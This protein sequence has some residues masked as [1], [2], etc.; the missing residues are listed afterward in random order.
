MQRAH[1][2]GMAV[3]N[4]AC[5]P[6]LTGEW[7]FPAGGV[8]LSASGSFPI[9][10]I[11]LER[12]ELLAGRTPRTI[13]MS[14]IGNDLQHASPAI[15][16]LIVYNSNPVAVAPQS[17][18]VARGFAREDLFTV[19]LEHF[20]TD[21]ADYADYILPA[22][23]QLEH[24]D[25]HCTYGHVSVVLNQPAIAPLGEAK[26]NAEIFR[27]L[28]RHMGYTDACFA[29]TDEAIGRQAFALD[30]PRGKGIDWNVLQTQG[31]Q[32]LPWT[33][34]AG[35]F[36]PFANGGFGTP[37]GK[38]EFFSA[39]MQAAGLDPVPAY[40]APYE[41][42]E[43]GSSSK[44]PLAFI[45]PPARNFL[46]STF[47]NVQSLRNTEGEPS[48]EL[49]PQDAAARGIADGD[50]VRVFND[51]GSL[52]LRAR[53]TDKARPR[54]VV[55]LSIWWKKLAADGKNAN[56]LVNQRL[57]DIGEAP[58]FYDCAVEVEAVAITGTA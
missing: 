8:L 49:H 56:E 33:G 51:R 24:F 23:T 32:R 45:S 35:A 50:Q 39:S 57:T 34:E 12:P 4:I 17:A 31:W 53:V 10:R 26:P 37:S 3:R 40:I 27:L 44:F 41:V 14:T 58:T 6:A 55:A 30:T 11:A 5:I 52:Q 47:V 9:D 21:T 29:D 25:V 7:R 28:A 36:A 1:G 48:V 18:E 42:P 43:V 54:V 15:E 16:A 22:T 46:N 2:G 20:Q 38:C 19:V 13:N